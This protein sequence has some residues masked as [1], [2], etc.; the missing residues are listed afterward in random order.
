[1]HPTT[2][3]APQLLIE[4]HWYAKQN[5]RLAG[6]WHLHI[7]GNQQAD[8][9]PKTSIHMTCAGTKK[10]SPFGLGFILLDVVALYVRWLSLRQCR[11]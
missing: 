9:L 4:H 8:L 3:A 6:A 5:R 10:P 11:G 1:M 7:S 2:Q